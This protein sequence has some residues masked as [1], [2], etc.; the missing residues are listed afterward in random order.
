M[1]KFELNGISLEIPE[2]CLSETLVQAIDEGRYE[3]NEAE[4]VLRNLNAKDRVLDLGAGAG[5]LSILASEVV[6]RDNVTAVEPVPDMIPALRKNLDSNGAGNARV[7]HAAV[8]PKDHVGDTVKFL[9]RRAF[10]ASE[11]A[12][13]S[14]VENPRVTSVPAVTIC[15]LFA[16]FQPSFVIMDVEGSEAQLC[17]E[18]WPEHVRIVVMEIHSKRYN[19]R[20]IQEI[21]DG[22]SASGLTYMPWGSRGETVVFQR[23]QT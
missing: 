16:R 22:M 18:P 10:W 13:D 19:S 11:I 3:N 23:V 17:R 1:R 5:Y 14:P 15:D 2:Q 20:T 6:G 8:V 12:S 7:V 4:A 21:F 9:P